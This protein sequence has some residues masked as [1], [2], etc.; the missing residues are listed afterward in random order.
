MRCHFQ[1][2]KIPI[3]RYVWNMSMIH[4]T[5]SHERSYVIVDAR[6]NQPDFA[7]NSIAYSEQELRFALIAMGVTAEKIV[8][9]MAQ[10][11][12]TGDISITM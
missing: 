7:P 6:S 4:V 10:L 11:E 8:E 5:K 2:D 3:M 12:R 1:R 9:H